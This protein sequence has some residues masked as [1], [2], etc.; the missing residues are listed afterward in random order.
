MEVDLK[1]AV[2]QV[3]NLNSERQQHIEE[4]QLLK[5]FV[6]GVD[7][8]AKDVHLHRFL[9]KENLENTGQMS[10]NRLDYTIESKSTFKPTMRS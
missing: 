10:T 2:Y 7:A 1:N 4:I 8:K 5:D 3:K 6:Y 9:S